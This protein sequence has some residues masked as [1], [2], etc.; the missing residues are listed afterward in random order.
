MDEVLDGGPRHQRASA[1]V[2]DGKVSSLDE[3]P[4]G[5]ATHAQSMSHISLGEQVGF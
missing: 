5:S 3:A 2:D 1:D 4:D